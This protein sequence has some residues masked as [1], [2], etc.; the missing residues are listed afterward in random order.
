MERHEVW[1]SLR[2]ESREVVA[3]EGG[4]EGPG[5]GVGTGRRPGEDRWQGPLCSWVGDAVQATGPAAQ[6]ST[7]GWLMCVC[8][9]ANIR[10]FSVCGR[11]YTC[12]S[13]VFC[14]CVLKYTL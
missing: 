13:H 11:T 10:V 4:V 6:G 3:V 7:L 5:D 14:R 2:C 9:C 8:V 12:V 1:D